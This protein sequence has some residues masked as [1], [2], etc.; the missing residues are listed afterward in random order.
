MEKNK[1]GATFRKKENEPFR[2]IW[3]R[4]G[5]SGWSSLNKQSSHVDWWDWTPY[6]AELTKS[7]T[8]DQLNQISSEITEEKIKVETRLVVDFES[9]DN[10]WKLAEYRSKDIFLQCAVP[11]FMASKLTKIQKPTFN[12]SSKAFIPD[13]LYHSVNTLIL[14]FLDF[15]KTCYEGKQIKVDCSLKKAKHVKIL[16][17]VSKTRG[18]LQPSSLWVKRG[19]IDITPASPEIFQDISLQDS[20]LSTDLSLSPQYQGFP[21]TVASAPAHLIGPSLD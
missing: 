16:I 20:S 14:A 8:K 13:P 9:E 15:H 12:L 19:A 4:R 5:E 21:K 10:A 17:T 3:V 1:I 7:R 6:T 18:C 2:F 11:F